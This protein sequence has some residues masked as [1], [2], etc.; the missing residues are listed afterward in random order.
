MPS[1]TTELDVVNR[2]LVKIGSR[3]ISSLTDGSKAARIMGAMID[4]IRDKFLR[5]N[6]W[7]CAV[8]RVQ[9]A[10]DTVAPAWGWASAYT[11]PSDYIKL[12]NVESSSTATLAMSGS[13]NTPRNI[14]Y[15][16]EGGKIL[17]DETDALN[18]RYLKRLTDMSQYD[19]MMTETLATLLAYEACMAIADNRALKADLWAEYKDACFEAKRNDGWEDDMPDFPEDDWILATL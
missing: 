10:K 16:I 4:S 14:A 5:K 8:E 13:K 12:L 17:C 7:N 9:I 3:E 19:P 1:G 6:P 11:L 15:K 2:A 18:V